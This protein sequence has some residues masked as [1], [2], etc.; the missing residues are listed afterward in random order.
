MDVSATIVQNHLS[1]ACPNCRSPYVWSTALA[2]AQQS[3]FPVSCETCGVTFSVRNP[4]V[5]AASSPVVAAAPARFCSSCGTKIDAGSATCSNCGAAV[6]GS[7]VASAAAAQVGTRLAATSGDAVATVRNLALDPVGALSRAY[8]TLGKARAQATGIA[9]MVVF[10]LASTIG[11]ALAA[12]RGSS[13]FPVVSGPSMTDS[14]KLF[15]ALLVFPAALAAISWGVRQVL[16]ADSSFAIDLFT[17]GSAVMPLAVAS[18]VSGLLGVSN[19]EVIGLLLLFALTYL[20]LILFTGL[21]RLGGLSERA[22]A[23]AVP[24]ILV[25]TAWLSKVVLTALM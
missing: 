21:S 18:F 19:F 17:C 7:S 20:I 10:S 5:A 14:L 22:A 12:K 1:F 3:S 11:F 2:S 25:L 13:M 15:L 8:E 24:V 6:A 4:G 23:P 16:R 9:L